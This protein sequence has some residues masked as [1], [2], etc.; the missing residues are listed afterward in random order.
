VIIGA[1]FM[2]KRKRNSKSRDLDHDNGEDCESSERLSLNSYQCAEVCVFMNYT[3]PYFIWAAN[4]HVVSEVKL[5]VWKFKSLVSHPVFYVTTERRV[6]VT[7][8]CF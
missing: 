8:D 5:K 2:R 7:E 1:V 6:R 3:V 4:P